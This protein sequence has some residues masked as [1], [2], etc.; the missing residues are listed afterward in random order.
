MRIARRRFAISVRATGRARY[1]KHVRF[2]NLMKSHDKAPAGKPLSIGGGCTRDATIG[3]SG[4]TLPIQPDEPCEG[5]THV[6]VG[7]GDSLMAS[8]VGGLASRRVLRRMQA[9]RACKG[10]Q[11]LWRSSANVGE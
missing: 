6:V 10:I 7:C 9:L 11:H 8:A 1:G 4:S 2:F 3:S 5:E